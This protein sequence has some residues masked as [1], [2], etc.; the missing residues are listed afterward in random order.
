MSR[1][2]MFLPHSDKKSLVI[3]IITRAIV[4][5]IQSPSKLSE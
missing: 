2:L 1:R 4:A 3:E 5:I